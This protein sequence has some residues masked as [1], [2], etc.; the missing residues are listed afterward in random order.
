MNP[1]ASSNFDIK[2][3]IFIDKSALNSGPINAIRNISGPAAVGPDSEQFPGEGKLIGAGNGVG[4]FL[5]F[6]ERT[7]F[8]VGTFG[9]LV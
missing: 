5:Y 2:I 8:R 6:L 4:L 1:S 7:V 3:V 9:G